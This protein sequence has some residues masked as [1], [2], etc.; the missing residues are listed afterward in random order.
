MSTHA[1]AGDMMAYSVRLCGG[2][3]LGRRA[4]GGWWRENTLYWWMFLIS[5]WL[6]KWTY[7]KW[8][9]RELQKAEQRAKELHEAIFGDMEER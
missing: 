6:W 2:W 1:F 4:W 8:T 5:H 3:T 7:P 9:E